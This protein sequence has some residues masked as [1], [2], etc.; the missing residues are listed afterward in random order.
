MQLRVL[1]N[2]QITSCLIA[3]LDQIQVVHHLVRHSPRV[4]LQLFPT[5]QSL[6]HLHRVIGPIT[7]CHPQI[8]FHHTDIVSSE[9]IQ[10]HETKNWQQAIEDATTPRQQGSIGKN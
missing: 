4:D 3:L 2:W 8:R 6:A 10:D 7:R 5:Y 9:D 1:A